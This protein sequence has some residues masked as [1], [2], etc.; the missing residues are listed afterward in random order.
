MALDRR[1]HHPAHFGQ[2]V[3]VRPRCLTDK[4]KQRLMLRPNSSWCRHGRH[5]L[6]ALALARQHQTRAVIPQRALTVRMTDH[7]R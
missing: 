2:D 7:A 1:Q 6:D 5:R 3:R 4:M